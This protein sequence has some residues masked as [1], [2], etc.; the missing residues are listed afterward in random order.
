MI[1]IVKI[2]LPLGKK[3]ELLSTDI[4]FFPAI[5]LHSLVFLKRVD[6]F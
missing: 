5:D 4:Q 1:E 2:S 6:Y 3:A